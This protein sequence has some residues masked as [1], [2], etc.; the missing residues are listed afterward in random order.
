MART[1][2]CLSDSTVLMSF[3]VHSFSGSVTS[4]DQLRRPPPPPRDQPCTTTR[5]W[6]WLF[7]TRQ[8]RRFNSAAIYAVRSVFLA[9]KRQLQVRF[10]VKILSQLYST[11]NIDNKA[12]TSDPNTPQ[13][14]R[15]TTLWNV[16]V[17]RSRWL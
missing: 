1:P 15:Y 13:A 6:P 3:T 7:Q 5:P 2:M 9:T 10:F 14:R 16:S 8:F 4:R 17:Q 12:V 11:I